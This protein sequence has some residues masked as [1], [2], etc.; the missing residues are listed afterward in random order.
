MSDT[1][2]EVGNMAPEAQQAVADPAAGRAVRGSRSVTAI[3]ALVLALA[4]VGFSGYQ[5]VRDRGNND[6]LRRDFAGRLAD[7]E[8]RNKDALLRTGQAAAALKEVEIKL[9]MLEAKLAESQGQQIALE[10]LY[11]EL[12]RSRD[13]WIVAE[14]EQSVLLASQQLQIAGNAHAALI[15]LENAE[16][17]LKRTDQSRYGA[18]RRVLNRDIERLKALPLIDVY[19]AGARIDDVL[20]A[21]EKLPLAMDARAR[22]EATASMPS[23]AELPGWERLLRGMWQELRQ[24]VRV[25]RV[26]QQD[27]GLLAPEQSFFLRENMKLR[28]LGARVALSARDTKS[29]QADL[30]AALTMLE[31]HF[32]IRDSAVIAAAATLRKLQGVPVRVDAPD[33]TD[34]LELLRKLRLSRARAPAQVA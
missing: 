10:T 3:L 17:R 8:A 6:A 16:T 14:I 23:P 1:Q 7:M 22:P 25:Q 11:Q 24:L 2:P 9:V 27:A 19:G 29:Y 4:A 32:D 13:E 18:L 28:L 20:A 31:R 26:D 30:L 12:S 33:L 34:T 5:W 21:L 15:G